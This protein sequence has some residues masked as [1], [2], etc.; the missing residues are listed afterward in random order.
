MLPYN[1][2][3]FTAS[4]YMAERDFNHYRR[5]FFAD[6]AATVDRRFVD[7]S[8]RLLHS[9]VGKDDSDSFPSSSD[10]LSQFT[11]DLIEKMRDSRH[12]NERS[13]AQLHPNGNIPAEL[14]HFA[15]TLRNNN[16]IVDESAPVETHVEQEVVEWLLREIARYDEQEASGALTTG[17][18]L[19]NLTGMMVARE[20]LIKG[21]G[22]DARSPVRVLTTPMAHYSIAKAARILGPA[23]LIET[24]D[25]P[26][27]D[28]GYKL[29][30]D[31]LYRKVQEAK[32]DDVP[33]MAIVAVA[34][35][36]ETGL[37]DPLRRVVEIADDRGIYLHVDGAYGGPFVLGKQR[38]L[39]DGMQDSDS[40]TVDPHK[41]L[42]TP[43]PA[44]S[45]L[46][47]SV[48]DHAY[49]SDF[50]TGGDAYLFKDKTL[51]HP[52]LRRLE[53]SMG[54]QGAS[55][56]LAVIETLGVEGLRFIL[57]H[58]IDLT[59][60]GYRRIVDSPFFTPA[61]EPELNTLCFF[62]EDE[63]VKDE[64]KDPDEQAALVEKARALLEEKTGIYLTTTSLPSPEKNGSRKKT[65]VFRLVPTHPYTETEHIDEAIDSLQEVWD[66]VVSDIVRER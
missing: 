53:G 49:I 13:M 14:A 29:N 62:P 42:Y 45:I 38:E 22:W 12:F 23:G 59:D 47:R 60:R 35:E 17:G 24:V 32:E 37:I 9:L 40:L 8:T 57:D 46:F 16:T 56:T 30:A 11:D 15:S 41:Y 58:T 19:A 33:V 4:G 51:H 54:G 44:G 66:E 48:N 2:D 25:V 61:F 6:P 31:A 20:K 7:S 65:K 28:G 10:D 39:F 26:M 34:G 36:T 27:D 18:T 50:N 3:G 55:A 5:A 52:G 21:G 63:R 64:L 1:P 43:Y